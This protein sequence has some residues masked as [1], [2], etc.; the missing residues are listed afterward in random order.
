[1]PLHSP[2]HLPG[3]CRRSADL[4]RRR[5][6]SVLSAS[7]HARLTLVALVLVLVSDAAGLTRPAS[8]NTQSQA[9][10]ARPLAPR[11]GVMLLP[12][13][14]EPG[15][16]LRPRDHVLRDVEGRRLESQLVW[17]R[18]ESGMNRE[19]WAGDG[20]HLRLL[21]AVAGDVAD[22]RQS[23][24]LLAR[25][26]EDGDGELRIGDRRLEPTW[27][28]IPARDQ[29][30]RGGQL[31]LAASTA[32][33]DHES[34]FEYWRW[35]LLAD[36]FNVEPP[37]PAAYG[38]HGRLVAEHYA[39]L[40]AIGLSR[41]AQ[42]DL[43]LAGR[44][45][46]ALTRICLDGNHAFAAWPVDPA[47]LSRLLGLLLDMNRPIAVAASDI[48]GWIDRQER[49]FFW[50]ASTGQ[51]VVRL[52]VVN[53]AAEA[54]VAQFTWPAVDGAFAEPP[55]PIAVELPGGRLTS[56]TLDRPAGTP[57]DVAEILQIRV[58]Q[59]SQQLAVAPGGLPVTPPG[60]TLP[61]AQR[62]L[63]L[64]RARSGQRAVPPNEYGTLMQI[65]KRQ[66]RW[67]AFIECLRP[68][69]NDVAEDSVPAPDQAASRGILLVVKKEPGDEPP[70][71]L[72]IPETGWHRLLRGEND[73]TLQIHRQAYA[74]RWYC[75]VVLPDAWL[76][77]LIPGDTTAVGLMRI[78]PDQRAAQFAPHPAPPWR[79]Q[80]GTTSLDLTQW[81]DLP[82]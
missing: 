31:A 43:D 10:Q 51:E 66:G 44:L 40:W 45:E 16:T 3:L 65:R 79:L 35:V 82:E 59:W 78:F 18:R 58:G 74:D 69:P 30:D 25:L 60:L 61:P 63:T 67:E 50:V 36:Q 21:P 80:P 14:L 56:V 4:C 22:A 2:L 62:A 38:E 70:V 11:G 71:Q 41:L 46:E 73:G 32:R 23:L 1:M 27:V 48:A 34:P 49:P 57:G 37:D 53:P 19:S 8:P 33:P 17:L 26:P 15:Q 81:S 68:S 28:D 64:A 7:Y 52:S 24:L 9:S 42:H 77:A 72:V 6:L 20:Q 29:S 5:A 13:G 47:A 54:V 75:R 39:S 76:G 55:V 12:L